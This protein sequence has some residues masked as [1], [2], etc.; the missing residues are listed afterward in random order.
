MVAILIQSRHTQNRALDGASETRLTRFNSCGIARAARLDFYG[1]PTMS[2]SI[3]WPNNKPLTCTIN[4]A[5]EAFRKSGRFK[6]VPKIPIILCS[7][8][9]ANHGGRLILVYSSQMP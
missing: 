6:P 2:R 9:R 3:R 4:I 1:D 5:L 7:V 8:F